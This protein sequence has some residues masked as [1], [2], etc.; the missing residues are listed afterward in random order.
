MGVH[1]GTPLRQACACMHVCPREQACFSPEHVELAGFCRQD[2]TGPG[3]HVA[4]K[5]S[6][7]PLPG[8]PAGPGPENWVRA[9]LGRLPTPVPARTL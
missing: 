6:R 3:T 2:T 8:Q 9:R 5:F 1:G 7:P 4:E